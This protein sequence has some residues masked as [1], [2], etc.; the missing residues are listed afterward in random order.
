MHVD[1]IRAL[2]V[3]P[4]YSAACM[5]TSVSPGACYVHVAVALVSRCVPHC[6][7]SVADDMDVSHWLHSR[8]ANLFHQVGLLC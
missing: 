5:S 1:V 8:I 6:R 7:A 4:R 3:R 2:N